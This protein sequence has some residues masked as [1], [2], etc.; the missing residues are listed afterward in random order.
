MFTG[1]SSIEMDFKKA[2][3]LYNISDGEKISEK[4][5][6]RR[7]RQ[8]CFET[9]V[10]QSESGTTEGFDAVKDAY[11]LLKRTLDFSENGA[12]ISKT[13]VDNETLLSDLG[14]GYP[15]SESAKTCEDC[16]GK[17]YKEYTMAR[18]TKTV[19]C[20]ECHGVGLFSYPCNKCRGTGKYR[21]PRTGQV[22]GECNLCNGSGRFFPENKHKGRVFDYGFAPYIPGTKR[23]G[24]R[25]RTCVGTGCVSKPTEEVKGFVRC[26]TCDGI[27]EVRMWNAVLPRGYFQTKTGG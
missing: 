15:I 10:D 1:K 5:L 23:K 3:E 7:Y 2:F 11:A 19:D 12:N 6:K 14:K 25:C 8:L 26:G 21:N 22:K 24:Y 27:G 13:L 20:E 16:D 4:E 9:H 17:G 18:G